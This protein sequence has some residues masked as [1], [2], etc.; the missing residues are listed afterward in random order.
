MAKLIFD[1]LKEMVF[2]D[3]ILNKRRVPMDG[4]FPR[5]GRSRRKSAGCR[6]CMARR[7]L[8]AARPQALV[9]TTLGTKEDEQFIDDL[10]KGEVKRRFLLH[11]NFPQYSVGE[12]G[13][14]GSSSRR[15]IGHGAF[16]RRALETVLPDDADF[17]YTSPRSF[18]DH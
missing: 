9:S 17:P 15:E 4:G 18:R 10:E 5:F 13:R 1:H 3:D 2:R 16:A 12:V 11:Y 7:C 6:A 14:F 8:H